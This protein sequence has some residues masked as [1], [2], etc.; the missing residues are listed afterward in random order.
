MKYCSKCGNELFDEA[1]ICPKCGCAVEGAGEDLNASTNL[2]QRLSSKVQINGIIW[3]VIAVIQIFLG[4]LVNW[5]FLIVGVLNII[6]GIQDI[7]YSKAVLNN[8]VGIV[9]KFKPLTGP[10]VVLI[11]N[12]I[13]GGLIG[14]AGSIYYLVGIRNFVMN[15]EQYFMNITK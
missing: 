7:N 13:F 6:S 3:L 9:D 10:I 15:N 4:L 1:V 5:V 11:Y 12:L 14:A 2:L 8:P